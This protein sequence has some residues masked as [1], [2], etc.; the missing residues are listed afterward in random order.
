VEQAGIFCLT[1]FA[2]LAKYTITNWNIAM[3]QQHL[4]AVFSALADPTRRAI[5]EHLAQGDATVGELAAP[6][7]LSLP[8]VSR[9]IDVLAD[10]GLIARQRQAQ[11][12][13]C[14][15]RR[16]SLV[17]ATDWINRNLAFW[18][19]RLDA[20]EALMAEPEQ[21]DAARTAPE[22]PDDIV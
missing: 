21:A 14:Q 2:Y 1:L 3:Q 9:H 13:R 5:L 8:T 20:L 16:E 17:E 18:N 6:F 7:D 10:A 22:R 15:F 19:E 12:R 4:N 11:W